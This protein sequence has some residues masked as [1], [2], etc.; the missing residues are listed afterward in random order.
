MKDFWLSC[1]TIC[2]IGMRAA[3]CVVTDEFLKVYLAR[4][5]LPPPAEACSGRAH[6]CMLRLIVE[7]RRAVSSVRHRWPLPI[8]TRAKTGRLID[9]VP[10]PP[11]RHPDT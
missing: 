8:R 2:S 7:P 9:R 5:E 6:I 4:P 1:G 11:A 10:G 3:A